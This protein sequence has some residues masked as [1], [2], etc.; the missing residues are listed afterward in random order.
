MPGN[1]AAQVTD[2]M[3]QQMIALRFGTPDDPVTYRAIA[4]K[5]G[6]TPRQVQTVCEKHIRQTGVKAPYPRRKKTW[7]RPASLDRG[8]R[9]AYWEMREKLRAGVVDI[10][11]GNLEV[12]QKQLERNRER[13]DITAN[14]SQKLASAVHS[15]V[16]MLETLD[17]QDKTAP[18]GNPRMRR[19]FKTCPKEFLVG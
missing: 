10:V 12:L 14:E 2:A 6:I 19:N 11:W 18:A 17:T 5:V 8:D 4:A 16:D 7:R 3:R 15:L 1:T 13:D 9:R